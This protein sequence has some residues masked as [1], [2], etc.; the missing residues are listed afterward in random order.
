MQM[1]KYILC[2]AF[3]FSLLVAGCNKPKQCEE[4]APAGTSVSWTDYNDV[5]SFRKYFKC[6][7]ETI[8]QHAEAK[9]TIRVMGYVYYGDPSA[10][11]MCW[12]ERA[13][14]DGGRGF[15]L[16]SNKSHTGQKT[17]I[18]VS[19]VDDEMLAHFR[20]HY[21]EYEDNLLY[22]T[23]TVSY[24]DYPGIP[25]CCYRNERFD[26]FKIDTIPNYDVL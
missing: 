16:T 13:L 3:V 1:K 10:E 23:G 5:L 14:L 21:Y 12:S 24:L 8:R 18:Y 17:T 9:D 25:G 6:H 7:P 20:T 11:E 2:F 19:V 26:V 4:Y 22:M 15:P